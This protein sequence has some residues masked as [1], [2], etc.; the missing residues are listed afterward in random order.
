VE[1]NGAL[2]GK[3]VFDSAPGAGTRIL[4]TVPG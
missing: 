4:G 1:L 2:G 3:L